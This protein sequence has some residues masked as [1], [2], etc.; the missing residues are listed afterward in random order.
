MSQQEGCHY[1]VRYL[2]KYLFVL[3]IGFRNFVHGALVM[4]ADRRSGAG[5]P[6]LHQLDT[7]LDQET[8]QFRGFLRSGIPTPVLTLH[9]D[10]YLFN[11]SNL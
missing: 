8:R 10:V 6:A 1:R 2:W 11:C 7:V 4:I 5:E 3:K 9:Q